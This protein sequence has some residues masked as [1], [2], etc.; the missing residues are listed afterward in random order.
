[1]AYAACLLGCEVPS[2]AI[3]GSARGERGRRRR[4]ESKR[5]RNERMRALL[6]AAGGLEYPTYREGLEAIHA[7]TASSE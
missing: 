3:V 6:A 7:S 2:A 4:T 1:M 5:V